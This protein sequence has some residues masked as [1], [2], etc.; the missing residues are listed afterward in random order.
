MGRVVVPLTQVGSDNFHPRHSRI[1][2][3]GVL[4]GLSADLND[5][6]AREEGR[7]EWGE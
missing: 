7:C 2:L 3:L 4:M 6:E 5:E 1:L